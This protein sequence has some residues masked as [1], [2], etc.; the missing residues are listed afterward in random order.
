[1]QPELA[2]RRHGNDGSNMPLTSM[3]REPVP[4]SSVRTA[5][6]QMAHAYGGSA[7]AR[8]PS[9]G[10][11][12]HKQR[13]LQGSASARRHSGKAGGGR[14]GKRMGRGG[15]TTTA[16]DVVDSARREVLAAAEMAVPA[17]HL[18]AALFR[19]ALLL[20]AYERAEIAR[21]ELEAKGVRTLYIHPFVLSSSRFRLGPFS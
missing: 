19:Q 16:T 7:S 2:H 12:R 11:T 6:T 13:H 3:W 9:P 14:G 4:P 17:S 8:L 20:N 21:L 15:A 10:R 1:M 5:R 18:P